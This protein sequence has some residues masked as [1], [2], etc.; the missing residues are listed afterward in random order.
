MR[1]IWLCVILNLRIIF[2]RLSLTAGVFD[3]DMTV[4]SFAD[5]PADF[6]LADAAL[7]ASFFAALSFF[8]SGM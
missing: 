4:L 2:Y 1:Y 5:A 7:A 8:M 3:S 6:D